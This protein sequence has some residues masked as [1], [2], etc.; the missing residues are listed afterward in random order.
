MEI[1]TLAGLPRLVPPPYPP[2]SNAGDSGLPISIRQEQARIPPVIISPLSNTTYILQ[3]T[4][5]HNQIVLL[6]SADQD[7]DELFWF[8][9]ANFLGRAKP[10]ERLLWTPQSGLWNLA[11]VDSWGISAGISVKVEKIVIPQ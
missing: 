9:N 5:H 7:N 2:D 11:V 8:A 3:D 6:A 1:F 4:P 10:N